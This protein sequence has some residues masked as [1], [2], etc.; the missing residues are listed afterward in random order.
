M[1]S[2]L[3]RRIAFAV[4]AIPTVLWILYLGA[5][6]L[7]G[8]VAVAGALG[9]WELYG[10]ARRQGVEPFVALGILTAVV[11]PVTFY[12][13]LRNSGDMGAPAW[14]LSWALGAAFWLMTIL[15]AAMRSRGPG[16]RPLAAIAVTVLGPLYASGLLSFALWLRHGAGEAPHSWLGLWWTALP[17]VIVWLCDTAAMAAG[18]LF[19]G[20]R[21]APVLS[22]NKT[23]AGAIAGTVAAVLAALAYGQLTLGR[24]DAA[25][26]A[27]QLA[28]LGV[29]V[30]VFG[31]IGDAAESLLKREAGVKDTSNLIPGHGGVLDRLD[32]LYFALPVAAYC[33]SAFFPTP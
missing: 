33:Y 28:V 30:S 12:Y 6:P 19:G 24:F 15:G 20:S 3:A 18:R 5:W 10:L 14:Y 31:Q 22:P 32:S 26:P 25:P 16:G 7:V 13:W 27:W 17:L 23:W 21:L 2:N 11:I 1:A 29:A 4:V 8:L 9:T